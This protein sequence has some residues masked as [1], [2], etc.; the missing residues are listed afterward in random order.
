MLALSS[1][2]NSSYPTA[3]HKVDNFLM[4]TRLIHLSPQ[5]GKVKTK[6]E[7]AEDEV[8]MNVKFS[9]Y[10]T[11]YLMEMPR[12]CLMDTGVQLHPISSV[13]KLPLELA[14]GCQKAYYDLLSW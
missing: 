5:S 7:T 13:I 9:H 1:T 3:P 6:I 10:I 14:M 8:S 11:Y 4:P 12:Q 2:R